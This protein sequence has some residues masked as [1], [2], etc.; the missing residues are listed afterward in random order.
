MSR[1]QLVRVSSVLG[2]AIAAVVFTAIKKGN[3]FS[4]T[5]EVS[6]GG[7]TPVT[8]MIADDAG[9]IRVFK[10]V[11]DFVKA[12]V[13]ASLISSA[14]VVDYSFSNI[15]ALEPAVFTG[16]IVKRAISQIASYNANITALTATSVKLAAVLALLPAVT[17]GEIAYKAE[18]QTQKNAVDDLKLFLQAEVTRIT[19]L[20][21]PV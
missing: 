12:A 6:T 9:K 4:V 5:A 3:D 15:E 14:A 20:L 17:P 13:K 2:A 1:V 19:A 7:A 10:N 8:A 18:K 11:D 16:D 21:P